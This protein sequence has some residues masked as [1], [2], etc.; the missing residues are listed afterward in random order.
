MSSRLSTGVDDG[1][2]QSPAN[3]YG[4]VV[5]AIWIGF[6]DVPAS[7]ETK[8]RTRRGVTG[9]QVQAACQWPA[10]PIRVGWNEHPEHGLRLL[11]LTRDEQGRLLR[12]ILS[13]VDEAD[14]TWR[15]RTVLVGE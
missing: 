9:D 13:P 8:I 12:V 6:I 15:L 11:V 3:F 10:V 7:I 14:G 5:S 2:A 4:V 1:N